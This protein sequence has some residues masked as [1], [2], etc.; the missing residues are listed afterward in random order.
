MEEKESGLCFEVRYYMQ[1]VI[2]EIRIYA[3]MRGMI[4]TFETSPPPQCFIF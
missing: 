4:P 3:E 1:K 2:L